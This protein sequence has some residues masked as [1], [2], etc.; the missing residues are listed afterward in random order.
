MANRYVR[1]IS[2]FVRVIDRLDRY[3]AGLDPGVRTR[4]R[5]TAWGLRQ[6]GYGAATL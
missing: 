3:Q 4:S 5:G 6:P 1:A 2:P